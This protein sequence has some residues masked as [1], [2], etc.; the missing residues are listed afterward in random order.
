MQKHFRIDK[1]VDPFKLVQFL[2]SKLDVNLSAKAESGVVHG[3]VHMAISDEETNVV[4]E[5][6][7]EDE[8]PNFVRDERGGMVV[9]K[10]HKTCFKKADVKTGDLVKALKEFDEDFK[11]VRKPRLIVERL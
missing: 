4:V 7:E 9:E 6:Y 8:G 11:G 10:G 3:A 5:F 1:S 2:E